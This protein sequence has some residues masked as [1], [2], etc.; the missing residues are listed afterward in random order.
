[1]INGGT[2]NPNAS[3]SWQIFHPHHFKIVLAVPVKAVPRRVLFLFHASADMGHMEVKWP[4]TQQ[5]YC[6]QQGCPY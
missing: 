1:M 3:L 4:T 2:V 6:Q 5:K